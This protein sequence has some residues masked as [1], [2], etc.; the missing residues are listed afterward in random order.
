MLVSVL[1]ALSEEPKS[2]SLSGVTS[3]THMLRLVA[4]SKTSWTDAWPQPPYNERDA[5]ARP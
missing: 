3:L 4:L 2:R 5:Q 1:C